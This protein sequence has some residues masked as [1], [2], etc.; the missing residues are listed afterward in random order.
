MN[1]FNGLTLLFMI[2]SFLGICMLLWMN[3]NAGKKWLEEL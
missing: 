1:M 2:G 3:T